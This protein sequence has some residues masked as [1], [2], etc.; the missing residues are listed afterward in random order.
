MLF[1][2]RIMVVMTH[3]TDMGCSLPSCP[4]SHNARTATA[5]KSEPLFGHLDPHPGPRRATLSISNG[6]HIESRGCWTPHRIARGV[7]ADG[8]AVSVPVERAAALRREY[9]IAVLTVVHTSAPSGG[10]RMCGGVAL[11]SNSASGAGGACSATT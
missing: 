4:S 10:K 6:Q 11:P 5:A 3:N 7:A 2:S 1:R 8:L 9:E